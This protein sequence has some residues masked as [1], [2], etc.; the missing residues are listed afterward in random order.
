MRRLC[1]AVLSVFVLL[2]SVAIGGTYT[3]TTTAREDEVLAF[4]LTTVNADRALHG[5]PA[6]TASQLF[7]RLVVK[8]LQPLDAQFNDAT[9]QAACATFATLSASEQSTIV[10]QLGGKT[11]C[12]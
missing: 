1:I 9:R 8:T 7:R 2:P 5:Q 3:I 11:P 12:P 6:L 10:T 4:Y